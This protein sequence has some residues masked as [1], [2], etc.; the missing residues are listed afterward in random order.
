VCEISQ[1]SQL[2][3]ALN[4]ILRN[5]ILLLHQKTRHYIPAVPGRCDVGDVSPHAPYI[6]HTTM[7]HGTKPQVTQVNK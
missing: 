2:N 3:D 7:H 5:C 6:I 4:V 1:Y